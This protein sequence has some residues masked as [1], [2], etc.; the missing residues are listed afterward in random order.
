MA[1][2]PAFSSALC[3]P[4]RRVGLDVAEG[5]TKRSN[6]VKNTV[7]AAIADATGIYSTPVL[8]EISDK[9]AAAR[10]RSLFMQEVKVAGAIAL[11]CNHCLPTA[12]SSG[13][14]RSSRYRTLGDRGEQI[15]IY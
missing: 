11:A 1:S 4:L 5:E 10:H 3:Y 14:D 8:P 15:W 12:G 6:T 13:R 9:L 2:R 7:I